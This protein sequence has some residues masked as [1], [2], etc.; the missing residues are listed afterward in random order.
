M[1]TVRKPL[2]GVRNIVR[3]NW[4]FYL[5]ALAFVG[6]LLFLGYFLNNSFAGMVFTIAI[7]IVFLTLV[8]LGV[9]CY[10]YDFSGLYSFNW[11]ERFTSEKESRVVNIH[12]GF[13]E[14]SEILQRKFPKSK[15]TVLDFYDPQKHTE[16]SIKRARKAYPPYPGT[17]QI[18]TA[19]L[20]LAHQSA[21]SVFLIFAAHEIR[22]M[23]ERELFFKELRRIVAPN[24]KIIVTEHLRDIPNFLAYT[25][26]FFHFYSKASW[27][28][29]F[30]TSGF[31]ISSEIKCTPFISTFI[32]EPDGTSP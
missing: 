23:K 29:L 2:Q 12:A 26:G 19:S 13:D 6:V 22:D 7:M 8:S 15:L 25:V 28:K 24:G 17:Q 16:V 32:L 27:K 10:I 21:D 5:L 20:P 18:T 14:T 31:K 3:F 4:H 9:S 30:K 11:M 1:A